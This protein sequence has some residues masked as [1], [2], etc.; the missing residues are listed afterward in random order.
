[1]TQ[2]HPKTKRRKKCELCGNWDYLTEGKVGDKWG[3]I[4]SKCFYKTL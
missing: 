2:G 3:K 4:C 1:M